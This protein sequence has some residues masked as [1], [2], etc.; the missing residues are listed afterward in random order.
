[1]FDSSQPDESGRAAPR[2]IASH[3]YAS[4]EYPG[5]AEIVADFSQRIGS[6]D[7]D[8]RAVCFG[9]AGP[10]IDNR[11]KTPNLPW[12]IDGRALATRFGMRSFTLINDLVANAEGIAALLPSELAVIQK[13]ASEPDPRKA[14]ALIAP[15]TGLGMAILAPSGD[16]EWIPLAS[17]GGH[18]DFA[19][20]SARE[21]ELLAWLMKRHPDHVSYERVVCGPGLVAV[22]EFLS[23]R[24]AMDHNAAVRAEIVADPKA[25][26]RIISEAAESDR[27]EVSSAAL[28]CFVRIYGAMAGNLALIAL[29]TGGVFLGGGISPKIRRRLEEGA[30]IDGFRAKGRFR[31]LLASLPVRLILNPDTAMLGAARRAVRDARGVGRT[32]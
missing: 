12:E 19:P 5:L 23:S 14:G 32:S 8:V 6:R 15:G 29:A 20:Q 26:P 13:G 27:C 3:S 10:V 22:Y 30:F 11:C 16:G 4:A 18:A 1:L 25:A 2:L 28:D 21:I 24:G 31:T 7:G 9:I 17:E